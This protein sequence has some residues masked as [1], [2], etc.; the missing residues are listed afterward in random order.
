MK[1]LIA[2]IVISTFV[3]ITFAQKLV[4]ITPTHKSVVLERFTG[5]RCGGC[6]AVGAF[7]DSV[8]YEVHKGKA[9]MVNFH[10]Q[11]SHY[12]VPDKPGGYAIHRK[13]VN[14]LYDVIVASEPIGNYILNRKHWWSTNPQGMW[15]WN[16]TDIAKMDRI[17]SEISPV[18][19]GL[20]SHY[21]SA[22]KT[23]TINTELFYT[24]AVS[25]PN[26][27]IIILKEAGVHANQNIIGKGYVD[28]VHEHLFREVLSHTGAK[29]ADSMTLANGDN[30]GAGFSKNQLVK[31]TYTFVNG[32]T[33]EEYNMD[34][35]TVMAYIIDNTAHQIYTGFEVKANGGT[36]ATSISEI[37]NK[38]EMEAQL[39]YNDNLITICIKNTTEKI[40]F[41]IFNLMGEKIDINRESDYIFKINK[42]SVVAGVYIYNAINKNGENISGKFIIN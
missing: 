31:K 18:N 5:V 37:K 32:S 7:L 28:Y 22:T 26:G 3:Q 6:P 16:D 27:L 29:G 21:N 23:L 42:S 39:I 34:S 4:S 12:T 41:N 14:Y 2:L 8:I 11:S 36:T 9:M 10:P 24:S 20:E 25:N 35:C 33:G 1:K 40:D 30:V 38:P 17:I 15:C 13:N 19:L